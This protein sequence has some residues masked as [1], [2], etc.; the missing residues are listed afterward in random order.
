MSF[1]LVACG[2]KDTETNAVITEE[3]ETVVESV[4]EEVI[5]TA[6]LE[7]YYDVTKYVGTP[8]LVKDVWVAQSADK[9]VTTLSGDR[10]LVSIPYDDRLVDFEEYDCIV[11]DNNTEEYLDDIVVYIFTE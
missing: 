11:V 9:T 7:K 5:D 1:L 6:N 3:I 4:E 8:R 2:T 10:V